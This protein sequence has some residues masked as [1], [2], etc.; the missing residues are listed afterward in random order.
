MRREGFVSVRL[1]ECYLGNGDGKRKLGIERDD[2]D[3]KEE[4]GYLDLG[5]RGQ[6]RYVMKWR[7]MKR[8]SRNLIGF[9]CSQYRHLLS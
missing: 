5:L 9:S 4:V 6:A 2:V 7:L 3:R 1:W 8:L